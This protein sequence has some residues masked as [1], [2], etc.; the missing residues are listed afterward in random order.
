MTLIDFLTPK[1]AEEIKP[2]LF[3]VKG[4]KGYRQIYPLAWNGKYRIKEQLSS[5]FSIRT[6]ITIGIIL[7][8]VWS[9]VHDISELQTAYNE[10][11][12][13]PVLFCTKVLSNNPNTDIDFSIIRPINEGET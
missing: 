9:Y 13:D 2:N 11:Y 7:F 10:V 3:I 8:L 1:D 4:K 6:L 5:V 12:A